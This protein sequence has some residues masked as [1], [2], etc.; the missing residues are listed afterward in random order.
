M[1]ATLQFYGPGVVCP[2]VPFLQFVVSWKILELC[3]VTR[4][5]CCEDSDPATL[6]AAPRDLCKYQMSREGTLARQEV[7]SQHACLAAH[8][9]TGYCS[10]GAWWP[11]LI[12]V[13]RSWGRMGYTDATLSQ[14]KQAPALLGL[15]R[16]SVSAVNRPVLSLAPPPRPAEWQ[17]HSNVERAIGDNPSKWHQNIINLLSRAR[18]LGFTSRALWSGPSCSWQMRRVIL[19]LSYFW[20]KNMYQWAL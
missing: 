5:A 6:V 19:H 14:R 11:H 9:E 10:S 4:E 3:A 18:K 1:A 17:I 2:E 8:W 20:H 13:L 7:G 16:A 15:D 12:S